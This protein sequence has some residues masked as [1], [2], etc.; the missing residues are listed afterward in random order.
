MAC[1]VKLNS[2]AVRLRDM[3]VTVPKTLHNSDIF[4]EKSM[5][6][7]ALVNYDD[8]ELLKNIH[9]QHPII[10]SWFVISAMAIVLLFFLLF[11]A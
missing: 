11:I 9:Q 4:L 7:L 6:S 5:P 10:I 8:T 3:V 1:D 2:K